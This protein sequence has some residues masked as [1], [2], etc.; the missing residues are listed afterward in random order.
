MGF[1][2]Q[3]LGFRLR[4]FGD[5]VVVI[6]NLGLGPETQET[7]KPLLV[8]IPQPLLSGWATPYT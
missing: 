5:A 8:L 4:V 7:T 1:G 3:V 6:T 2:F